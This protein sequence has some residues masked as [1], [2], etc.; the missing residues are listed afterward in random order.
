MGKGQNRQKGRE[1]T[2]GVENFQGAFL[3]CSVGEVGALVEM[4]GLGRARV[5]QGVA[6]ALGW[7]R[8]HAGGPHFSER[9]LS[10]VQE[11]SLKPVLYPGLPGKISF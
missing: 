11:P 8:S 3:G 1:E 5:P 2:K 6:V 9:Y 7:F 4:Q 10:V